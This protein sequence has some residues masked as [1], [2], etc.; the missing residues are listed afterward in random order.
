MNFPYDYVTIYKPEGPLV[1][2]L[3]SI[4]YRSL[5]YLGIVK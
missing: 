3:P 5:N 4:S 2:A 1:E